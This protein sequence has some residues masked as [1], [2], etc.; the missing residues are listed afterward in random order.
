MHQRSA[1]HAVS[2]EH[3]AVRYGNGDTDGACKA[4]GICEHDPVYIY[5]R[6][7]A[8]IWVR[9]GVM[10]G[11]HAISQGLLRQTKQPAAVRQFW[12]SDSGQSQGVVN[13]L[14]GRKQ[15]FSSGIVLGNDRGG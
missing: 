2:L 4:G 7:Y 11:P 15:K 1:P 12:N 6:G 9:S 13:S 8:I 5:E 14:G 10:I 3:W